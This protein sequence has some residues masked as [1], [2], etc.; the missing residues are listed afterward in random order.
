MLSLCTQLAAHCVGADYF[1][2]VCRLLTSAFMLAR[3]MAPRAATLVQALL[4]ARQGAEAAGPPDESGQHSP[5]E[6]HYADAV[7]SCEG[8]CA[9]F[10]CVDIAFSN[11]CPDVSGYCLVG[12]QGR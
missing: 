5:S 1:A 6:C 4:Q 8:G 11:Q 9:A 3:C 12:L 7:D 10:R 2:A